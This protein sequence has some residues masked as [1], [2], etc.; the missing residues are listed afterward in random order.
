MS[1]IEEHPVLTF[2][3]GR[4]VTFRFNGQEIEG[5][6]GESVAAAL[7]AAGVRKLHESEVKHRPRGLFCAI[8]NCSSCLMRVDGRDNVRIC[9]EPLREGMTV[10]EAFDRAIEEGKEWRFPGGMDTAHEER[11]QREIPVIKSMGYMDYH[12]IVKDFLEYGRIIGAAPAEKLTEAPLTIDEA[13]EWVKVNGWSD[14]FSIGPGRGSAAVQPSA[15]FSAARARRMA[16]F[17]SGRS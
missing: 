8:G 13:A 3:K 2:R 10:E 17:R 6:E 5:Y 1:R 11:L 12:L 16:W 9:V 4:K 14:G 15:Q 7:H